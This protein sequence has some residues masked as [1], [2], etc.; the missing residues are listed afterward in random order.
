MH[1]QG[2]PRTMQ[3]NPRYDDV[4]REVRDFLV[5]RALIAEGAGIARDR[6]AIDPGLRL[7]QDTGAQSDAA[8]LAR[9]LAHRGYPV[10]AGLS[11]KAT[12]G[13]ITGR[14]VGDRLAGSLAAALAAVARGRAD[15][16]RA[17]CARDG[18]RARGVA[19]GSGR[20]EA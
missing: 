10:V 13:A 16:A 18:R 6:I 3:A 20:S 17:R 11:R 4:V 12:I 15:R 14:D 7:R 9:V 8:A 19:I 5:E 2:E 1:M